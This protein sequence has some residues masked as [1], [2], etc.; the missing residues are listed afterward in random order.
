LTFN[1]TIAERMHKYVVIPCLA[2]ILTETHKE[3]VQRIMLAT[4]RNML[5]KVEDHDI[6]RDNALQ[7]VQC[8]VLKTLELL[9]EKKHEDSELTE[10]IEYLIE[11]LL[12]SVQDLS[13]FDEYTTEIRSGR[14]NW[15]PVHK[16]EK[17]WRENAQRFNEKNFEILKM[18]IKIL[19]TSTDP[20]VLCVASHDL[21]EY[22]RHYP[23][24]K[25]I[26]E[27]LEGKQLVMRLL[28]HEDPNVRYHALLA[29][30]KIMVHN[31]EYLGRQLESGD[32]TQD[33]GGKGG[34]KQAGAKSVP[35]KA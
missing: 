30:Q 34:A 16:S 15:S 26:I 5:D 18:L 14:L 11:K 21:G 17:F 2:D 20:L 27:K 1:C 6:V 22:V 33:K 19:E 9:Q 4:F 28:T 29:I 10:D 13:S 32:Q 12:N 24:G 35:A 31:W 23:R 25:T 3:K 8:K 7:M